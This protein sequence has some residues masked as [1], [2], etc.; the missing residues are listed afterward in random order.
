MRNFEKDFDRLL[1]NLKDATN[2]LKECNAEMTEAL[3]KSTAEGFVVVSEGGL[4]YKSRNTFVDE[5]KDA[6]IFTCRAVAE[7]IAKDL[8]IADND[9][10]TFDFNNYAVATIKV[11]E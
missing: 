4:F 7:Q 2:I 5:L 9:Y 6:R 8:S 1:N 11:V 10:N 3:N